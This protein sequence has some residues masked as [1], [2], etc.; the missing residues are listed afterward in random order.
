M[1]IV[2]HEKGGERAMIVLSLERKRMSELDKWR[3]AKAIAVIIPMLIGSNRVVSS[4][5]EG[6]KLETRLILK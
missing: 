3:L 2:I 5:S 4:I 6:I 1:T